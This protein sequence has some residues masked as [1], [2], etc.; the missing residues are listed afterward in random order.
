MFRTE[1]K[2]Q[3]RWAGLHWVRW[4]RGHPCW[5][6]MPGCQHCH[7]DTVGLGGHLAW[8]LPA[9]PLQ[10]CACPHG[11][12]MVLEG[13]QQ[14]W[15][16]EEGR[17]WLERG[18][19]GDARRCGAAVVECLAAAMCVQA[20]CIRRSTAKRWCWLCNESHMCSSSVPQAGREH[21]SWGRPDAP[22]ASARRGRQKPA[23][24]NEN[25]VLLLLK[26]HSC[27]PAHWLASPI[28]PSQPSRTG[29]SLTSSLLGTKTVRPSSVPVHFSFALEEWSHQ[30]TF[31]YFLT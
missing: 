12:G 10:G 15:G 25:P 6:L 18:W 11:C 30:E 3:Q 14:G 19:P 29:H 22:Q 20:V 24:L 17:G 9:H 1:W 7:R 5:L 8:H 27:F 2:G 31:N 21:R 13:Q 23:P 4:N 16:E 28:L 26:R